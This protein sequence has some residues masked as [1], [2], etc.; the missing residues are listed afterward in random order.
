MTRSFVAA[1]LSLSLSACWGSNAYIVEGTVIE[2]TGPRDL[3]LDHE[4]IDGLGMSA[5]VMDFRVSDPGM[6]DGIKPGDRVYARMILEREG[7]VLEKLRVTGHRAIEPAVAGPGPVRPGGRLPRTEI[8]LPDG[9]SWVVGEGQAGPTALTFLYTTCPMPEF[10]PAIVMRLQALQAALPE[11]AYIVAVTID[12]GSDTPQVLAAYARIVGAEGQWHFARAE[13]KVLTHLA[14]RAAL[15]VQRGGAAIEHGVRLLVLD[16]EGDLVERYDDTR[17]PLDR[18][19]EQLS[20]GGP[21]APPG[22]SGTVTPAD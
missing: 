1:A 18:V 15:S 11:G 2:V 22:T 4:A 14:M 10:C 3:V 17:W 16:A 5:M 19:V 6:L 9:S 21:P 13:G 8:T 12:P 7:A 20:T